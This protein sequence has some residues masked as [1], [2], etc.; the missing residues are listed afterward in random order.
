MHIDPIG[1]Q[2]FTYD[3][4]VS[5]DNNPQKVIALDPQ[6]DEH[7]LLTPERVFRLIQRSLNQDMFNL[8]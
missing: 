6:I 4:P 5:C 1:N 7:Y 2:T 8:Q 3:T